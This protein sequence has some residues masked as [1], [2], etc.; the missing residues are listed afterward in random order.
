[1][2]DCEGDIPMLPLPLLSAVTVAH[3]R[4]SNNAQNLQRKPGIASTPNGANP[5]SHTGPSAPWSPPQRRTV[6]AACVDAGAARI[7]KSW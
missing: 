5:L 3:I 1:M 7:G 4:R 2:P 6:I